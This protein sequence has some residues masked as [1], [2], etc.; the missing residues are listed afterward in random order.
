MGP[1]PWFDLG[2]R[3]DG[4]LQVL[5][6]LGVEP[7]PA[8]TDPL[9]A[10]TLDL[11][12]RAHHGDTRVIELVAMGVDPDPLDRCGAS[13]L[14]YG[15]RSVSAGIVVALIDAGA[16]AGRRIELSPRGERFTTILHEI[17]RQGRTVALS[18]ALAN[19][20]DPALIDSEGATPM[21][22]LGGDADH[23]NPQIVRALAKA[24]ASVNAAMPGGAQPIE[25]AA[26]KVLPA[27]VAALVELGADPGRGLDALMAWWSISGAKYNG[28][29]CDDVCSVIDIL[30]AGGAE[31][32]DRDLS[33]AAGASA[34]EAAL[35]R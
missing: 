13:P 28:Y 32:N 11:F 31:V 26:R 16:D 17:V 15:V 27:T 23:V 21:H 30:R 8:W 9:A 2:D 3:R 14:W 19:G 7:P 29:R 24:G 34:V 20:A 6:A 12:Q 10:D 4:V 22:V 35:R 18:H 25:A 5:A 33:R 1:W